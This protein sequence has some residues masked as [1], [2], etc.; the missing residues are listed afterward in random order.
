VLLLS[1]GEDLA[2]RGVEAAARLRARGVPVH[3]VGYG[4]PLGSKIAVEGPS[5][6]EFLRDR[7]GREIVSAMDPESLRRLAAAG[8]GEFADG[9][10]A[11]DPLPG[12]YERRVLP[13]GRR[14]VEE[15][16]RRGRAPRYQWALALALA[17]WVLE[18]GGPWRRPS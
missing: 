15:E 13:E 12:L 9:G 4:S 10:A 7:A 6:G 14:A 3:A 8:G 5:G 2:G 18:M 17:A 16:E 1:D 11:G